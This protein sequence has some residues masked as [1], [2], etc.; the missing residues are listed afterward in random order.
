M[1]YSL[2][3]RT[4]KPMSIRAG[5]R[6]A[7]LGRNGAG[8][9]TLLQALSG[10]LEPQQGSVMLDG[11][12]LSHIDPVD[13]RR[14]VGLLTQNARLF[15]GTLRENLKLGAPLA[16]DEQLLA[17]MQVSGGLGFLQSLPLGLDHMIKEGGLGIS[18]GQRQSLLLARLSLRQP[19]V[20]LL[21]EPTTAMDEA[22]ER[23]WI[24]SLRSASAERSVI[25]S[26]QRMAVLDAVDRLIVLDGGK[27]YTDGPKDQVLNA[28][29]A[30]NQPQP[31]SPAGE[32]A[33]RMAKLNLGEALRRAR[34]TE[35]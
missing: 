17:A 12:E 15:H 20:L 23:A 8:K 4:E 11:I 34:G 32:P 30:Q 10:L 21:D 14:D 13:V 33:A 3:A 27:I 25:I 2:T 19:R 16:S 31:A 29:R 9:S 18:G 26:T 28:L 24:A 6:I 5:E 7:I 22:A 1:K 35:A